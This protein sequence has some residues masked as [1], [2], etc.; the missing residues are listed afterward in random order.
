[1]KKTAL[2]LLT[3]STIALMAFHEFKTFTNQ[4]M[5]IIAEGLVDNFTMCYTENSCYPGNCIVLLQDSLV[6]NKM[7]L[8]DVLQQVPEAIQPR[9][10]YTNNESY[11]QSLG[12]QD[13]VYRE[14]VPWALKHRSLFIS[15]WT[16][17]QAVKFWRI[18]DQAAIKKG[19]NYQMRRKMFA[20]IGSVI[21]YYK[22]S[23]TSLVSATPEDK[24]TIFNLTA[25]I[26]PDY[27]SHRL[28]SDLWANRKSSLTEANSQLK[29]KLRSIGIIV[30]SSCEDFDHYEFTRYDRRYDYL[31][32]LCRWATKHDGGIF[33]EN[34]IN[35]YKMET[36]N[37]LL[38]DAKTLSD[39]TYNSLYS[40]Q[41][42]Q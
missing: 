9:A 30:P 18:L 8:I 6:K 39:V 24:E 20:E 29:D 16:K 22:Q 1:M 32:A 5:T 33:T 12:K 21:L 34:K 37:A 4:Q 25:I 15:F 42:Q 31:F 41:I 14:W 40:Y 36:V 26:S 38:I 2:F 19:L 11:Y 35:G 27:A 28:Q 7:I 13:S 3:A 23:L 17:S 10:K